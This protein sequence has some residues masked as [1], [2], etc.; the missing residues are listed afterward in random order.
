MHAASRVATAGFDG[1]V[2]KPATQSLAGLDPEVGHV[3]IDYE[4]PEHLPT[5]AALERLDDDIEVR[6]TAPVRVD[7]FDPHGA[8]HLFERY[9]DDVSFALVAGNPAYLDHDA[10]RRAVTPRLADALEA[11]PDAWVG[12]EGIERIALA[13]GATQYELLSPRTERQLRALRTA[14]FEGDIAVYAPTA[15]TDDDEAA[16]AALEGYLRRRRSVRQSLSETTDT[17]EVLRSAMDDYAIVGDPNTARAR[18]DALRSAG[19]TKVVGHPV[20]DGAVSGR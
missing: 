13:T 19:A 1:I 4:G 8:D 9:G 17:E 18:I 14:G 5:P 10:A 16:L 12:T 2:I 20:L 11:H 15:I 6:L 3:L 7:G